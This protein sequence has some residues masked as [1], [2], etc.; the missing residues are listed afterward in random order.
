MLTSSVIQLKVSSKGST[1]LRYRL[2]SRRHTL[3]IYT[4]MSATAP[5]DWVSVLPS[6]HLLPIQFCLV[7]G[8]G[9]ETSGPDQTFPLYSHGRKSQGGWTHTHTILRKIG[10]VPL[11]ISLETYLSNFD[12]NNCREG[13]CA[14]YRHI[15][16][17]F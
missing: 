12:I 6:S 1:R 10:F 5:R 7:L 4:H 3:I 8:G 2:R 13:T 11:D 16:L 15:I 17:L 14:D 9:G